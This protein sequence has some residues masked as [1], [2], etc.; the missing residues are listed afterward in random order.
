MLDVKRYSE[1]FQLKCWA[2]Y[3]N[4]YEFIIKH[5]ELLALDTYPTPVVNYFK[6]WIDS[7]K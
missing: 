2:T 1:D 5:G 4:V 7:R 6:N 3:Y